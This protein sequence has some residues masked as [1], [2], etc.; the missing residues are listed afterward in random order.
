MLADYIRANYGINLKEEKQA[1]VTGRLY[2]VLVQNNLKNF[3]EYFEYIHN[4]KSGDAITTLINKITTNHTFFM[5]EVEHFYYLR[6][7][8]LHYLVKL[9]K[10]KD[11]R[12]WSAG[13]SS[14]EEPY[15]L[16]MI[17]DEFLGNEKA[18]WDSKVLAA[19]NPL[20]NTS[21]KKRLS[22]TTSTRI[23]LLTFIFSPS[24]K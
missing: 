5:R 19:D 21:R 2:N 7:K 9:K 11:L 23:F 10:N 22:S 20:D 18:L 15:T 14:G 6:D 3:S 17:I 24:D 1:L 4:D 13:C 16:A 8:V 12:I